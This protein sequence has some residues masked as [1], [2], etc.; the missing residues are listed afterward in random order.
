LKFNNRSLSK[1]GDRNPQWR[2][3][4]VKYGSL[5]DWV[6]SRKKKPKKC[7][8]CLKRKKLELSN[9]SG[10]YKRDLSDWEYICRKCHMD[11][12]GR[13]EQ[14]RQS[15]K[16]RKFSNRDCVICQKSYHPKY[17]QQRACDIFCRGKLIWKIRRGEL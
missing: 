4:K 6:R 13:N 3:D 9:K 16:S 15:G 12:D 1:I 10:L 2:E 17:K 11:I 7:R 14:L 8:R 5:H